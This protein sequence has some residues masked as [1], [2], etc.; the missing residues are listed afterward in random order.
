MLRRD[1]EIENCFD[2]LSI[3]FAF[4]I[5]SLCHILTNSMLILVSLGK[6][7]FTLATQQDPARWLKPLSRCHVFK[8]K[9]AHASRSLGTYYLNF[10]LGSS[11]S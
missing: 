6:M 2:Q 9:S 10:W 5:N 4:H 1:Q 8:D 7:T 11:L 3:D